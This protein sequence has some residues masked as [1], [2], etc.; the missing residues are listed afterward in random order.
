MLHKTRGIV[1]HQ[2]KYGDTSIVAHIYTELFGRQSY[3]VKGA[4]NKKQQLRA[5]LFQ[6]LSLLEMEV[7]YK[8]SSGLQKIR[9]ARNTPAFTGIPFDFSKNALS[10]F[11]AEI[12]YRTLREEEPNNQL[13]EF[14][15]NAIQILDLET[16]N[17]AD[18]HLI[19]LII[20][21][22]HLGFY[23]TSNY[24][25]SNSCFDLVNGKYSAIPP[26]HGHY[27]TGDLSKMFSSILNKNL[28]FT[29]GTGLNHNNRL[30]IL[31][32]ILQYFSFHIDGMKNIKSLQVLQEVFAK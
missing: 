29:V 25:D 22:K 2:V 21:S 18:F 12:L 24:S 10:L 26:L 11:I 6:P 14:V 15:F 3:L 4:Y 32:M 8:K 5:G 1:L 27:I 31:N 9:E 30:E 20:L 28:D 23:P 16:S 19:F 7:Y 13:F 17:I